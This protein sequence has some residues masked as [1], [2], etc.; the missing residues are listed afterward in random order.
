[1]C[2]GAQGL[3]HACTA[4]TARTARTL[5]PIYA[6]GVT[7]ISVLPPLKPAHPV[8]PS[9]IFTLA[10]TL[11]LTTP[12]QIYYAYGIIYSNVLSPFKS[13]HPVTLFNCARFLL[14][15][16]LHRPAPMGVSLVGGAW[17]CAA[18]V[19]AGAVVFHTLESGDGFWCSWMMH[20]A[21]PFY[22]LA[23]VLG[24]RRVRC[25]RGAAHGAHC[26]NPLLS[27]ANDHACAGARG[28]HAGA[29]RHGAGRVQARA[30]RVQQAAG[31][32]NI[33]L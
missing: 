26:C 8:T 19:V 6:H 12:T 13:T 11:A 3:G 23:A 21:A 22:H 29:A 31:N 4:H 18:V 15:R 5:T 14:M 2:R 10:L 27:K 17:W 9:P 7:Y 24:V 16:T 1:M 25:L 32:G 20:R 30:L 28:V 33:I